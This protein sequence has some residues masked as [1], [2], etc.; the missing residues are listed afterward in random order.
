M[1]YN[2]LGVVN[3]GFPMGLFTFTYHL[4]GLSATISDVDL[5]ATAGKAVALDNTA[6]GSVK[7]AGDGD[8]IF[9]RIYVAE[10]RALLNGGKVASVARKFKEKLP[11]ATGHGIAVG[12]R[13]VGA[14]NGLVK[15]DAAAAASNPIV[16]ESGT[17]YVVAEKL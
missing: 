9:G 1:A 15:K 7:M 12:D 17:D 8:V 16:I 3:D 14:G 11:A 6:A 5:A 13:I 10:N 4:T 2:I